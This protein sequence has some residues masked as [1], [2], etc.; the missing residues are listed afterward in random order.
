MVLL[1]LTP[2]LDSRL[3]SLQTQ[4]PTELAALVAAALTPSAT[5]AQA[6][7]EEEAKGRKKQLGEKTVSHELLVKVSKWARG[8]TEGE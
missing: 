8:E 4:L 7:E 6:E 5:T 2:S 3:S 1:H